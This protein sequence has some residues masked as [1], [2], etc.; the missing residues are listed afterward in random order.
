[1]ARPTSCGILWQTGKTGLPKEFLRPTIYQPK[2]QQGADNDEIVMDIKYK[3]VVSAFRSTKVLFLFTWES[4]LFLLRFSSAEGTLAIPHTA[5]CREPT[6]GVHAPSCIKASQFHTSPPF[7][8]LS[9]W[10]SVPLFPLPSP[11]AAAASLTAPVPSHVCFS[12]AS[13][14]SPC[15]SIRATTVFPLLPSPSASAATATAAVASD[16]LCPRCIGGRNRKWISMHSE[17]QAQH[18]DGGEEKEAR[19]TLQQQHQYSA[20]E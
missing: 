7:L 5:A 4:L 10:N 6:A 18:I 15:A 3:C 11:H 13:P 12:S 8:L 16:F 9:A 2:W 17:S 14:P 19:T 1:M 20:Q